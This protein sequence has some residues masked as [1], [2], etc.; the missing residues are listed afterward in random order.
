LPPLGIE[1]MRLEEK[2]GGLTNWAT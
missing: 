1:P 2:L